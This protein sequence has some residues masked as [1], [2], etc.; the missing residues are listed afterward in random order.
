[1]VRR[2]AASFGPLD[3]RVSR[4]RFECALSGAPLA[5][6]PGATATLHAL[7]GCGE[8]DEE[9]E[10]S[11][12]RGEERL[13]AAG[14][15]EGALAAV[16]ADWERFLAAIPAPADAT[17]EDRRTLEVAATGLRM[18]ECAPRGRMPCRSTYPSKVHFNLFANWDLCFHALGLKEWDPALAKD[19]LAMLLAGQREDGIICYGVGS[20]LEPM[21]PLI[22]RVSQPPAAGLAVLE[23][24]EA[25]GARDRAWLEAQ[26]ERLLRYARWWERERDPDGDGL[27]SWHSAIET[28]WDDTPRLP[29]P[30]V[31]PIP[32]LGLDLGNLSG[33]LSAAR[34]AAVDLNAWMYTLYESLA[35]IARHLGREA[36]AADATARAERL[37]GRIEAVLWDESR[38]GYFDREVA[39]DGTPGAFT[40]AVTPAV[41]WPLFAGLVRDP[42]RA[43]RVVEGFLLDPAKLFGDPDDP[44]APRWPVPTVA[45]DD[46]GYDHAEDGYYWRGQVWLIPSYAVLTALHRYGYAREAE[47]LRRRLLRLVAG[48]SDGGI[49][50]TYDA[51][52]GAIGFGSGSLSGPGEPA[53]FQIGLSTA[54]AALVALRAYERYPVVAR[55]PARS[56]P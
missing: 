15:A 36:D 48:A 8:T 11:L 23:V 12:R 17:P 37:A 26:H 4:P 46:P 28:G 43:A 13:E 39:P 2:I 45:Y 14:G 3:V 27:F 49:F 21:V 9:A 19:T 50:E 30:R 53:C 25:D 41:A 40:R 52:T 24:F 54:V 20:D 38:G 1:F 5:L 35:A 10:A 55:E 32:A 56:A 18:S 6:E 42:A 31:P 47:T 29:N 7:V 34:F 44:A 16:R 22:E 51:L 33:L